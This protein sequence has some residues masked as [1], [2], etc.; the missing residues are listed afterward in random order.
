MNLWQAKVNVSFIFIKSFGLPHSLDNTVWLISS[1]DSKK[2]SL[3]YQ[4]VKESS[5]LFCSMVGN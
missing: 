4:S 3:D 5:L 2:G 1:Q